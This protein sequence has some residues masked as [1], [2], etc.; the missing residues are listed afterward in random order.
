MSLNVAAITF[1]CDNAQH[2][3]EF[4]SEALGQPLDPEPAASPFFA[5][6]GRVD[7]RPGITAMMFIK[8]PEGKSTK[9]RVHVDLAGDDRETEVERLIGLGA[10]RVHDKDEWGVRWTTLTDPEGN[11]FC[12]GGE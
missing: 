5:S 4:W 11:E 3:A 12:I 8:V 9:N 6:L 2:V 7:P 1:D 10:T